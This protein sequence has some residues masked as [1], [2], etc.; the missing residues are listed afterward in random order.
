MTQKTT[1]KVV[2]VSFEESQAV[3]TVILKGAGAEADAIVA[4][5]R[6][7]GDVAIVKDPHLVRQLYRV[8][9]D[10]PI[11]R[12][13]FPVMAALLAHIIQLDRQQAQITGGTRG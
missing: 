9:L 12:E 8:P 7:S 5:A 10:E 13:L 4:Q 3:P 1:S 6:E 11:G 2:G